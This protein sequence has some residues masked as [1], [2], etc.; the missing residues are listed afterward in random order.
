MKKLFWL[1]VVCSVL[2]GGCFYREL[3]DAVIPQWSPAIAMPLVSSEFNAGDLL[4]T[5]GPGGYIYLDDDN[6]IGL[7]YHTTLLS[8]RASEIFEIPDFSFDISGPF[9]Q[10]SLPLEFAEGDLLGRLSVEEGVF[11][12]VV[13]W[14][15]PREGEL[16]MSF[17]QWKRFGQIVSEKIATK[18]SQQLYAGT[19]DLSGVTMDFSELTSENALDIL[20]GAIDEHGPVDY[21]L[22]H[23]TAEL[24]DLVFSDIEGQLRS[25]KLDHRVD[26]FDLGVVH[27]WIKGSVIFVNPRISMVAESSFGI[28]LVL[29]VDNFS[30]LGSGGATALSG[31]V[32]NSDWLIQEAAA[33]S[34]VRD[35]VVA[36]PDNSNV[37]DFLSI[38][39][40]RISYRINL[41]ASVSGGDVVT[42]SARDHI[43]VTAGLQIPLHCMIQDAVLLDTFD[44]DIPAVAQLR[45]MELV[46]WFENSFPHAIG[47]QVFL[48]DSLGHTLDSLFRADDLLMAS[49]QTDLSGR[50]VNASSRKTVVTF[51]AETIARL[52]RTRKLVVRARIST[53]EDGNQPVRYSTENRLRCRISANAT[54]S[55]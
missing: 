23:F 26:T 13:T 43:T 33:G 39:P 42:L 19:I 51:E 41:S 30:G 10:L 5:P 7:A 52:Y 27:N 45:R 34:P 31:D 35:S 36:V 14:A 8:T 22:D 12:Y 24:S 16:M 47:T 18:A 11:S 28:P 29:S 25:F 6:G 46:L 17:P 55:P 21:T 37:V 38:S 49:G 1:T 9:D 15:D 3:E 48:L 32:V 53:S 40:S 2:V 50:V 54:I 20:F 44:V 4:G